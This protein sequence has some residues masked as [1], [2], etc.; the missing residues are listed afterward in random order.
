MFT[1]EFRIKK[2]N[3]VGTDWTE[4]KPYASIQVRDHAEADRWA[5][6]MGV[7]LPDVYEVRWANMSG[8]VAGLGQGNYVLGRHHPH[9]S[10]QA[11]IG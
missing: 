6:S 11:P 4:I 7:L 2:T 1:A 3:E 8:I 5:M 9:F 10:K